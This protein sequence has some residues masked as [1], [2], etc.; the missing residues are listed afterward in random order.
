MKITDVTYN[1][2][3]N[4]FM[5]VMYHCSKGIM[6]LR[7]CKRAHAYLHRKEKL[8]R[9][10]AR[11]R[12]RLHRALVNLNSSENEHLADFTHNGIK[13]NAYMKHDIYSI[14]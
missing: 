5:N 14:L 2:L 3:M 13:R 6:I 11:L 7:R 12:S 9:K 10:C 4:T 8:L 1:Y